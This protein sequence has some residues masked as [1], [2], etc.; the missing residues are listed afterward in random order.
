MVS[1]WLLCMLLCL[2]ETGETRGFWCMS[3]EAITLN[4]P[5]LVL[6][7]LYCIGICI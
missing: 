7:I 6:I 3:D 4:N 5:T 2:M 1:V